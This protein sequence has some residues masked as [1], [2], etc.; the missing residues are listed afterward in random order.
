MPFND[1]GC[2]GEQLQLLRRK[3]RILLCV[4]FRSAKVAHR[5]RRALGQGPKSL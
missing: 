5:R 4:A 2:F 3:H 1:Q